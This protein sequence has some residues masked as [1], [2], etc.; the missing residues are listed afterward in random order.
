MGQLSVRYF[1]K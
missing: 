1:G